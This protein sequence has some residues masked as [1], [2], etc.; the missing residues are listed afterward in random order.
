MVG[1]TIIQ[2]H[3][4]G[5]EMSNVVYLKKQADVVEAPDIEKLVASLSRLPALTAEVRKRLAE[6][7]ED[8]RVTLLMLDLATAQA[9]QF[10]ATTDD[11]QIKQRIEDH[12]ASMED[13]LEVARKKAI[14]L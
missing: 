11:L 9:R 8:V 1:T 3:R 12:L 7:K 10:A 2:R 5:F 4:R 14:A 6:V 13:L